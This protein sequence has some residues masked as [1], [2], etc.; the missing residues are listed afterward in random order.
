V[1]RQG[2]KSAPNNLDLLDGYAW[3]LLTAKDHSV[4][5]PGVALGLARR[6][7]KLSPED[8]YILNTLGLAEVSNGLWD[9][10]IATLTKSSATSKGSNPTDFL[11]L[12][13]AYQGRGDKAEAEKNY[14]HGAEMAR[15]SAASDPDL[16]MLWAEAATDLGKP[17]P[18]L[19]LAK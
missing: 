9:E 16:R 2:L 15:K 10:A 4:R 18:K 7:I 6:A 14:A 1:F 19:T 12:A 13:M 5:Q 8:D 17:V 11:F 3:I